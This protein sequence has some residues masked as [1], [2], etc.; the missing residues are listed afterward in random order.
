MRQCMKLM[1]ILVWPPTS[2]GTALCFLLMMEMFHVIPLSTRIASMPLPGV[3]RHTSAGRASAASMGCAGAGQWHTHPQLGRI[4]ALLRLAKRPISDNSPSRH[5]DHIYRNEFIRRPD[6]LLCCEGLRQYR[7]G[8]R[9]LQ[10]GERDTP[11]E[12]ARG[13]HNSTTADAGRVGRQPG[14]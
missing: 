3:C 14:T 11:D 5:D 6:L 8:K 2:V 10:R 1:Q 4:Q 9:V 12:Y 13:G 7:H